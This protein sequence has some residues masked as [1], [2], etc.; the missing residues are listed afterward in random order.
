MNSLLYLIRKSLKNWVLETL[1]KPGRLILFI[2]LILIIGGLMVLSVFTKAEVGEAMSL[3]MLKTCIFGIIV[4]FF[5]IA[6]Y[7]GLSRGDAI[8]E[9]SDVNLLFVSPVDP[10]AILLYGI[11]RMAKMAFFACFFILFQGNTLSSLFGVDAR[12]LFILLAGFVLS[13]CLMQILT[14]IIYTHTNG[15][16]VR[17]RFVKLLAVA[18]FIPVIVRMARN[19]LLTHDVRL[20][21]EWT[22]HSD[23]ASGTPI[24]GWASTGVVAFLEGQPVFGFLFFGMIILT[25]ALLVLYVLK[26]N[27]DYYE[28]VLVATET[29]FEKKRIVAE[30]TVDGE[31]LS[32][33]KVRVLKTGVGGKGAGAIFRKHL[34]ESSRAG[35]LGIWNLTSILMVS[36]A[37]LLSVLI[38]RGNGAVVIILQVLMWTQLFLIGTSRGMKELYNHYIYLIPLNAFSK[39]LWSNGEFM[40]RILG[41]TVALFIVAGLIAR[42]RPLLVLCC[43]LVYTLYNLLLIG[44]NYLFQRMTGVSLNAGMLVLIYTFA[45]ILIMAP[46]IIAALFVGFTV[47]GWGA[48]AGLLILGVWELIAA[49]ICFLLSKSILH[50]CDMPVVKPR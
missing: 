13:V 16:P 43:I 46:G 29:A 1:R 25:G 39:V 11:I 17:K 14:L 31:A 48:M 36:G 23:V 22:M 34:R 8:F 19:I 2:A 30:G 50:R 6:V 21:L 45:T 3:N 41:E 32:G 35:R 33:R 37:L 18:I 10:S 7:Q 40:L 26:S 42:E 9:M 38:G 49:V 12:G 5:V 15:R 28:D 27:P 44:I 20:A 24:A 47:P 4:L